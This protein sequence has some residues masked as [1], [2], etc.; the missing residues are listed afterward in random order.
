MGAIMYRVSFLVLVCFVAYSNCVGF[1]NTQL[2][3]QG[4]PYN[5]KVDP[6]LKNA[7]V[8]TQEVRLF[9][10]LVLIAPPD[11][12]SLDR[13]RFGVVAK[14]GPRVASRAIDDGVL[15]HFDSTQCRVFSLNNG[16]AFQLQGQATAV[17]PSNYWLCPEGA[18][19]GFI[20]V[21]S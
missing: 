9:H 13:S 7:A 16:N 15:V 12:P 19:F 18:I 5:P 20:K 2:S 3:R 21:N 10:D 6:R 11:Q 8:Y 1:V 17:Q 14:K 4:V